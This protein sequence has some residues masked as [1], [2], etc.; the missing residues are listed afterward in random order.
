LLE[1]DDQEMAFNKDELMNMKYNIAIASNP[2]P[3]ESKKR[4]MKEITPVE[5]KPRVN[6]FQKSENSKRAFNY[7]TLET[8]ESHFKHA[9]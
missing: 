5:Q 2:E 4:T 9:P 1:D 3:S 7:D 6:P 8:D